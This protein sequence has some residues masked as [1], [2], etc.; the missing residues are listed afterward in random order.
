MWT[1]NDR[2]SFHR[3]CDTANESFNLVMRRSSV[4]FAFGFYRTRRQRTV[5]VSSLL[6]FVK[7]TSVCRD[8]VI[9]IRCIYFV[10]PRAC[11]PR[12]L[13]RVPCYRAR[14]ARLSR[15]ALQRRRASALWRTRCY[16]ARVL[17]YRRVAINP[18]CSVRSQANRTRWCSLL[19]SKAV[20]QSRK[21]WCVE[22]SAL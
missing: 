10:S 11:Y 7:V 19:N 21:M 13:C 15:E 5:A 1:K 17:L 6:V 20:E 16:L 22:F 12:A 18:C 14:S 9:E 2:L 8:E 3:R 4:R